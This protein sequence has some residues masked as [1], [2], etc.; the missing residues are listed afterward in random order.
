MQFDNRIHKSCLLPKTYRTEKSQYP[1]LLFS[2]LFSSLQ[3]FETS[4]RQ[5]CLLTFTCTDCPFFR[6]PFSGL[7]L[8]RGMGCSLSNQ[9]SYVV[10]LIKT[11]L[12]FFCAIV[13]RLIAVFKTISF[14]YFSTKV[15]SKIGKIRDHNK[16]GNQKRLH[17]LLNHC[18]CQFHLSE[19]V[20]KPSQLQ[21]VSITSTPQKFISIFYICCI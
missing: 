12:K 14:F 16:V 20:V 13:F 7:I 2:V 10:H 11:F 8:N 19:C 17:T 15:I 3:S 4:S 5:Q 6:G 18:Q 21:R 1:G 9:T